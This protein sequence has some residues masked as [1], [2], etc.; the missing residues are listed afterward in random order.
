MFL[1]CKYS[2]TIFTFKCSI[3]IRRIFILW[4]SSYFWFIWRKSLD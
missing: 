4:F 2:F 1:H 3:K